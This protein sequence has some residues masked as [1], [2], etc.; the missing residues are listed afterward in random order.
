MSQRRDDPSVKTREPAADH[1]LYDLEVRAVDES[2][3]TPVGPCPICDAQEARVRFEVEGVAPRVVVCGSC[4]LG[5]LHPLPTPEEVAAFYPD[6]YY[7]EPGVKFQSAVERVVRIVGERHLS[8]LSNGL[9]DGARVLG[10]CWR[11]RKV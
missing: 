9:A 3:S 4:G 10:S 2:P 1:S 7:G 6:E 5:R 11:P 8:F